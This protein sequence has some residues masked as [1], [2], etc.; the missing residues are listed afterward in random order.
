MSSSTSQPL[1]IRR[2][3]SS[4]GASA[5]SGRDPVS[6]R[7]RCRRMRRAPGESTVSGFTGCLAIPT[8]PLPL[9]VRPHLGAAL[10]TVVVA[11]H[12]SASSAAAAARGRPRTRRER[13][14]GGFESSGAC[15]VL[16]ERGA[17]ICTKPKQRILHL[18]GGNFVLRHVV[19]DAMKHV[20]LESQ[21]GLCHWRR[22]L[23][24]PTYWPC[25][26]RASCSG[27][28]RRYVV[29]QMAE[30]AVPRAVFAEILRRID[31]LRPPL[32]PDNPTGPEPALQP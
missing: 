28:K 18:D 3:I 31:R 2:S 24:A 19:K 27:S 11:G 17:E 23:A 30:V 4:A 14:I 8:Q 29:F 9:G 5:T 1:A 6:S 12:V 16:V 32:L 13:R 10:A 22:S 15:E 21:G 7:C 26:E 25:R 20:L